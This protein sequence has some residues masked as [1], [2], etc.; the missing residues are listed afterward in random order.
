MKQLLEL[1]HLWEIRSG[2]HP[3]FTRVST[4]FAAVQG[5]LRETLSLPGKEVE[6]N[7]K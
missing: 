7:I 1:F 3:S 2:S 5:S 4:L 6:Q